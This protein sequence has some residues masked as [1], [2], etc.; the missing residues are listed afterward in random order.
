MT[1]SRMTFLYLFRCVNSCC[2]DRRIDDNK[3][4]LAVSMAEL[5]SLV[6]SSER[7]P[8]L[9]ENPPF[10][11]DANAFMVLAKVTV[12]GFFRSSKISYLPSFSFGN[13]FFFMHWYLRLKSF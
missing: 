4:G 3:L 2:S 10:A 11:P 7:E 6:D 13:L 8:L 9:V 12:F 1:L 5:L